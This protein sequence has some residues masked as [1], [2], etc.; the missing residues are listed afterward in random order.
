MGHVAWVA[1]RN[2]QSLYV[3]RCMGSSEQGVQQGLL[4]TVQALVLKRGEQCGLEYLFH[5]LKAGYVR[6]TVAAVP[7]TDLCL[8]KCLAKGCQHIVVVSVQVG[9]ANI[10]G[11]RDMLGAKDG[12]WVQAELIRGLERHGLAAEKMFEQCV[13]QVALLC[14]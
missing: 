7:V 11:R 5:P 12:W 10:D 4:I 2:L 3:Y 9:H 8:L 13:H 6:V 14:R 1:E